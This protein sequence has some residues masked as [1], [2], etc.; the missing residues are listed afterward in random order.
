MRASKLK[1]FSVVAATIVIALLIAVFA[2]SV[3][4]ANG[5]YTA[6]A[7]EVKPRIALSSSP[8]RLNKAD[9]YR[10]FT[11][12]VRIEGV[13]N[14]PG[15]MMAANVVLTPE[16]K[17]ILDFVDFVESTDVEQSAIM[18][19][20]QAYKEGEN[21]VMEA[22]GLSKP[23]TEDFTVG[24]YTFKLK[25][26]IKEIPDSITFS[27]EDNGSGDSIGDALYLEG[28]FFTI[29]FAEEDELEAINELS[30]LS[31][32]VGGMTLA[33]GTDAEQTVQD[34]ILY[35]DRGSLRLNATRVGASSSIKVVY[36]DTK[37]LIV[38]LISE[39]VEDISA[40]SL[41]ELPF[42]EYV[43]EIIVTSEAGKERTYTITFTIDKPI[44]EA[45]NTL[46][47]LS[48]SV[49]GR[50]VLDGTD[51]EQTAAT[52]A[53]ADRDKV[54]ISASRRGA[55]STIKVLDGTKNTT[56]V[57]EKKENLADESLGELSVG[58]HRILINVTSEAGVSKIYTVVLRIARESI[59][60]I[61]VTSNPAEL[62]IGDAHRE[63]TLTVRI[64]DVANVSDGMLSANVVLTP[65]DA[66]VLDF[67]KFVASTDVEQ[68]A[69]MPNNPAYIEG[70]NVVLEALSS[71]PI[72]KDF[73]I[74]SYTFKLKDSVTDIPK[75]I[76]FTYD[77][78]GASDS[79]GEPLYLASGAFTLYIGVNPIAKPVLTVNEISYNGSAQSF[80]PAGMA[81]LVS[82]NKVK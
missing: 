21:V 17:D 38:T 41:G 49:D 6:N 77:D 24:G 71:T 27:Y 65:A 55:A 35:A 52:I 19:N 42:G 15:G 12:T 8:V 14:F 68:S 18:P 81:E 57:K 39:R 30:A 22:I 51:D 20:D 69:I 34:S 13:E 73:I 72:K 33:S 2:V 78:N 43:I 67:V 3:C 46:D 32:T 7:A 28:G 54:A 40:Q 11:V 37:G 47:S 58:T 5:T 50:V 70:E 31:L 10:E 75:S 26:S 1:R 16:E 44:F 59:P 25:D 66:S 80:V 56:L 23:M 29:E 64:E 9:P 53:Y 76:T 74:G 82:E 63:F 61:V 79:T 4:G 60:K 48:I 62:T 36:M 45:I